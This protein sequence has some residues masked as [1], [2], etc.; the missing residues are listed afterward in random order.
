[1]KKLSI[2]I[3]LLISQFSTTVSALEDCSI[4]VDKWT[5]CV[6]TRTRANGDQYIGEWKNDNYSGQGTYTSANGNQ[7]IGEFKYGMKYGQGTKTY[8]SSGDQYIGEWK[9]DRKHGQGTYTSANGNQYI[10]EFKDSKMHGQG[11]YTWAHGAQYIGE[12]KDDNIQG[13][14]T[15][16][17]A[18]GAQYIG[19]WKDGERNGQGTMTDL[20]GDQ[21]IGEWK[22]GKLHGRGTYTYA[23]GDI[24]TGEWKDG[25]MLN[26]NTAQAKHAGEASD[27]RATEARNAREAKE[28]RRIAEAKQAREE[29]ERRRVAEAK[30]AREARDRRIAEA[31]QAREEEERRRVAEK[32]AKE[33]KLIE[34]SSGTGFFIND[35]GYFVSNNHVVEICS[36]VKTKNEGQT[37]TANIIAVDKKNDL[38]LGKVNFSDNDYISMSDDGA[39]LG[40]EVIVAGFPFQQHLSE[41]IK[42]TQ[43]IIS[44]LSGPGNDYSIFQMDAAVQPGN[45]G[46]P[47]INNQGELIGITVAKANSEAFYEE[48][49]SLPENINFGIKVETLKPFLSANKIKQPWSFFSSSN[50]MNGVELADKANNTTIHLQCWNT[51]A[52]LRELVKDNK[53]RNLLIDID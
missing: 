50:S 48:T 29:E 13:Q 24:K 45:S 41:S 52:S 12:F 15:Y 2:L 18:D 30:Q 16:T 3:I 23:N 6:G 51:I 36:E 26:T 38:A 46:G 32:I 7:Y 40:E 27:R 8:S 11:T 20:K 43:G 25:T 14:G 10:G 47:I 21:Y 49:G 4:V 5:D 44:S 1:M 22:D 37:Y 33:N 31:K 9:F 39:R 19:E 42:V 34:I 35:K 28:R 53:V 17:W